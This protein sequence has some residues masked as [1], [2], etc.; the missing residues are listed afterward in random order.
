M[1]SCTE[2]GRMDKVNSAAQTSLSSI[3]RP[4]TDLRLPIIQPY[5]HSCRDERHPA[6]MSVRR[7]DT[8]AKFWM[9]TDASIKLITIA[10]SQYRTGWSSYLFG[11]SHASFQQNT[12][13]SASGDPSIG[14][15]LFSHPPL[16]LNISAADATQ[17]RKTRT[18]AMMRAMVMTVVPPEKGFERWCVNLY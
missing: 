5:H 18:S 7:Q 16:G 8:T 4:T 10:V 15:C 12:V 13:L 11:S 17:R 1:I 9:G 6:T 14:L 2:C 3:A